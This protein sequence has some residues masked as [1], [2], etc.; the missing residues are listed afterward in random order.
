MVVVRL[1]ETNQQINTLSK[2]VSRMRLPAQLPPLSPSLPFTAACC[3]LHIVSHFHFHTDNVDCSKVCLSISKMVFVKWAHSPSLSLF[4][5]LP[6]SFLPPSAC[7]SVGLLDL[8]SSAATI[9]A[10]AAVAVAAMAVAVVLLLLLPLLLLAVATVF[11]TM[12][13][14]DRRDVGSMYCLC[15]LQ[16]AQV[17]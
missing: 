7:Q 17:L 16:M 10:A 3:L 2:F 8:H 13:T 12:L 6:P 5:T 11:Q 15:V 1:G 14:S 9:A 4:L